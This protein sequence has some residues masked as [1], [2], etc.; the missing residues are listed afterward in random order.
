M[1]AEKTPVRRAGSTGQFRME[2]GLCGLLGIWLIIFTLAGCGGE[3]TFS[4]R[5]SFAGVRVCLDANENFLCDPDEHSVLADEQGNFRLTCS[6][7]EPLL[8]ASV[9]PE[10]VGLLDGRS[11][12]FAFPLVRRG[13]GSGGLDVWS[14]LAW[15]LVESGAAADVE[16]ARES[17]RNAFGLPADAD[18]DGDGAQPGIGDYARVTEQV[19]LQLYGQQFY[20]G[21]D[22]GVETRERA[23]EAAEETFSR[24]AQLLEL[25][26]WY[27][28]A[29]ETPPPAN[30]G[31]ATEET[32][33]ANY[34]KLPLT[35]QMAY[36]IGLDGSNYSLKGNCVNSDCLHAPG[37]CEHTSEYVFE[38]VNSV[39]DLAKHLEVGAVASA[40]VSVAGF[41]IV[42]VSGGFRFLRDTVMRDD[43]LYIAVRHEETMCGYPV[44]SIGLKPEWEDLYARDYDRFRATCGDRYLTSITTGGYFFGLI[45]VILDEDQKIDEERLSLSGKVLGIKVFDKTWTHTAAEISRDYQTETRVISNFFAYDNNTVPMDQVVDKYEEFLE[46]I[47]GPGCRGE[48]AYLTCG[49]LTSFASYATATTA[50]S[51]NSSLVS[52]TLMPNMRSWET[53]YFQTEDILAYLTDILLHPTHY[54]IGSDVDS[55][56]EPN[57]WTI[58]QL[59]VIK[60]ELMQK[61]QDALGKWTDCHNDIYRCT[62]NSSEISFSDDPV[63][64]TWLDIKLALPQ[65]KFQ[66]PGDCEELS[67]QLGVVEDGEYDLYLGGLMDRTFRVYCGYQGTSRPRMYL[68]VGNTSADPELPGFNYISISDG[69]DDF[70]GKTY[71]LLRVE[72]WEDPTTG[73]GHLEVVAPQEDFCEFSPADNTLTE[74]LKKSRALTARASRGGRASANLN[75]EGTSFHLRE[76]L[77]FGEEGNVSGYDHEAV[78]SPNRK[79]LDV[80]LEP[81]SQLDVS[82]DQGA[83]VLPVSPILL[84]Y[85]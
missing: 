48:N 11:P 41:D 85:D 1:G 37:L 51:S 56:S 8:I 69:P 72:P 23:R 42:S 75:L 45:E 82:T 3:K 62:R 68:V 43:H 18:T 12:G 32:F 21:G 76:G 70:S 33:W 14:T 22:Q 53:F 54:N 61:N 16:E 65:K 44:S 71:R 84:E 27:V 4:G 74:L 59:Q 6:G 52:N 73:Q 47:Q 46:I 28:E 30:T 7:P 67:D 5:A 29:D 66:F 80:T 38:L 64:P 79:N 63:L 31:S 35:V 17:V 40:G 77:T 60:D 25:V 10:S 81:N 58:D 36:G 26:D 15:A 57:S 55:F 83:T 20:L 9:Q 49:Y 24:A 19:T 2:S 78:V 34:S 50:V 39:N 13:S